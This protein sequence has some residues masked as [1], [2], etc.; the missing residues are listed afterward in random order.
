MRIKGQGEMFWERIEMLGGEMGG[1][2][3]SLRFL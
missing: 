3:E 1:E 2:R